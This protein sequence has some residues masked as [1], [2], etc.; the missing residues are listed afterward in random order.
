MVYTIRRRKRRAT[1][2]RNPRFGVH[3]PTLVFG[4]GGW[5]RPGRKGHRRSRLF[6]Q[7]TRINARKRRKHARLHMRRNPRYSYRRNPGLPFGID[8]V[9]IGGL[10]VAGGIIAGSMLMPVIVKFA[11]VDMTVKYRKFYGAAHIVLGA[12]LAAFLK[13]KMLK[14][15]ALIVAATGIYDLIA[16]NV[17]M[18]GLPS[19][20]NGSPL[21]G[22]LSQAQVAAGIHG[23]DPGVIGMGASYQQVGADYAPALGAS[24]G[25]D[26]QGADDV[27]YGDDGVTIE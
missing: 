7:P 8:R 10:K 6:K 23:D 26:V 12:A 13:N 1:R 3:R 11:P 24:Y 27:S 22:G 15:M 5:H 25:D 2:R 17:T 4:S 16:S 9:A 21:L 20:P 14:D 18:L 19:L